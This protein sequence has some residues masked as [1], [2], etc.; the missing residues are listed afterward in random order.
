M[1]K[2]STYVV[3]IF[4]MNSNVLLSLFLFKLRIYIQ[5]SSSYFLHDSLTCRLLL[6]LRVLHLRLL[7]LHRDEQSKKLQSSSLLQFWSRMSLIFGSKNAMSTSMATTCR[8]RQRGTKCFEICF[9]FSLDISLARVSC[10]SANLR[11]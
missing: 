7:R 11:I 2:H 9:L 8:R 1:I 6:R 5:Q 3:C 4:Y 10:S